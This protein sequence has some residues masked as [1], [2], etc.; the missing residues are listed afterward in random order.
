GYS[1]ETYPWPVMRLADLYLLYAE[2]LN[3][4]GGPGAEVYKWLNLVRERAGLQSVEDS[5]TLYSNN[6]AKYTTQDGLRE[7][8]HR[9]RLIEMAFEG[10][11]YW[12]LRRWKKADGEFNGPV[13]GWDVE[14][15][16]SAT[17]YRRKVLFNQA[18]Q[19][20]RDYF[21][22]ISENNIVV[23]RNL[24]QNPGW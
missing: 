19:S 20:P 17:Y 8:I 18:F 7:I 6:P 15:E 9:E 14:Q 5:W 21:W 11:R 1:L 22:P 23:N 24:V 12:D 4:A 2:A 10:H 3:E 13:Y 16:E